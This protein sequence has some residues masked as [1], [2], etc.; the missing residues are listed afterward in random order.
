MA[1]KQTKATQERHERMLLELLKTPGNE[2]CADCRAKNPRWASY[3]L[4]IF[5][6]IRC[7]GLHR[8]MGT[9]IS[10]VKSVTMDQWTLEQIEMMRKGGGNNQVNAKVNPHPEKHPLPLEVDDEHAIE[11]YVRNKWE[12]RMFTEE[13]ETPRRANTLDPYARLQ[14][15]PKRSSSVPV[16][17]QD[18]DSYTTALAQ[19]RQM[20]FRDDERNLQ[21]LRQT[22]GSVEASVDILSRLPGVQKPVF[23]AG[24]GASDEQK[25]SQ[26]CSMGYTDIAE[27]QDVLRRSGG[28]LEVAISLL[29]DARN[30]SNATS[31]VSLN[32]PPSPQQ[33][34][35]R[36][37]SSEERLSHK[38]AGT[39]TGNLLDIEQPNTAT[40]TPSNPFH[41]SFPPQ[42]SPSVYSSA[43][44][45]FSVAPAIQQVQPSVGFSQNG[46]GGVSIQP[47][48]TG[49][50]QS[51][52]QQGLMQPASTGSSNPFSQMA[53]NGPVTPSGTFSN[54]LPS[55]PSQAPY[56]S[57][58]FHTSMAQSTFHSPQQQQQLPQMNYFTS[59]PSVTTNGNHMPIA[60][61]ASNPWGS[62]SFF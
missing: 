30:T 35:G 54:H 34:A 40:R 17:L 24:T 7:A 13:A 5:L 53:N 39:K 2:C 18:R 29:K 19:L 62:S 1:E 37:Q 38:L 4:G 50:Q 3:S 27:N 46:I 14:S 11:K 8:K 42:Q 28:N 60:N 61:S 56:T 31:N 10:R 49:M 57:Y 43:V 36:A 48:V 45:P 51:V 20:G 59:Q 9:H 12:K 41:T 52:F 55:S 26:L 25:I 47:Q 44:N 15:V 58:P 16:I 6:C 33:L 23:A 32:F 22:Q 21:I